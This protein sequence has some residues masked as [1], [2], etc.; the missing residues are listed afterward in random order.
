MPVARRILIA[1][2]VLAVAGAAHAGALSPS[3]SP[4]VPVSGLAFPTAWFDPSRL[5]VSSTLTVG[6]GGF[7]TGGTSALQVTSLSYQ[8][9]PPLNVAVSVGNAF[10]AGGYS[11]SRMFLE[12]LNVAWRPSSTMSFQIQYR[13]IRSPLQWSGYTP[14][15]ARWSTLP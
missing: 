3:W 9:A 8:I 13:D 7:G 1:V 6:S 11:S 15:A 2:A 10:G 12:G 4:R 14:G 5:H